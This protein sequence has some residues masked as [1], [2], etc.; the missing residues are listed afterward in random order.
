[1]EYPGRRIPRPPQPPPQQP[2]QFNWQEPQQPPPEPP[3]AGLDEDENMDNTS[4]KDPLDIISESEEELL[5]QDVYL[6][7][8]EA[9]NF[10]LHNRQS[11]QQALHASSEPIHWKDIKGTP[12]AHLCEK[13][14]MQ[15][16][17]SLVD[18]GTFVPVQ[19][20][21]GRRAIGCRWVFKL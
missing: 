9:F 8:E 1:M 17:M 20:P 19:L 11:A 15:E 21:P 3:A 4:E 16:F 7:F 14:A 6:T 13:A 2:L 10:M 12:D 5:A 18:N